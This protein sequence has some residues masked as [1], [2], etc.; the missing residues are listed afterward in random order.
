M[1][2]SFPPKRRRGPQVE[3]DGTTFRVTS[4]GRC[5]NVPVIPASVESD[6]LVELDALTHWESAEASEGDPTSPSE[7]D[8]VSIE[9]LHEILEAI[10]QEAERLGLPI[11]FE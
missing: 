5:L 2:A 11:E 3:W 9:D 4:K 8:E 1:K 10:E 7:G 6:M